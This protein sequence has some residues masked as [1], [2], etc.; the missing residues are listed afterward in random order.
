MK[1]YFLHHFFSKQNQHNQRKIVLTA[2]VISK[3]VMLQIVDS[4]KI[5]PMA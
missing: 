5:A 3:S 1:I 4:L 2:T